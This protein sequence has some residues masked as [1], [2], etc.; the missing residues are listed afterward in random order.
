MF[1]LWKK[2]FDILVDGPDLVKITN[3]SYLSDRQVFTNS[4][5]ESCDDVLD[6]DRELR[7][8]YQNLLSVDSWLIDVLANKPNDEA[9]KLLTHGRDEFR[10]SEVHSIS[11]VISLWPTGYNIPGSKSLRGVN[12]DICG[13]LLCPPP[14]DWGD[15]S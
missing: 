4:P 11:K 2:F 8:D 1:S 9:A 7:E 13:A 12:D 10:N 15:P 3:P 5:T 6:R 14:Y